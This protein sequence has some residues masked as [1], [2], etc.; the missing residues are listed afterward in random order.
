MGEPIADVMMRLFSWMSVAM[1]KLTFSSITLEDLKSVIHLQEGTIGRYDWN[2]VTSIALTDQEQR[3]VTEVSA[4]LLDRDT[5]LMNEAT[6]WGKAIFP[7]LTLAESEN[8]EAWAEVMLRAQYELFALEGLA[9][10]VLGRSV[11][12]RV[13]APYLVVVEAKKGIEAQSPVYQLYGQLLAAAHLNWELDGEAVQEIFGCYTIGDVW[14]FVRAEVSGIKSD[15]PTL[16]T[17][18]SREYVEKLEAETILKLLKG[19]VLRHLDR[20]SKASE[21]G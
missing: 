16:K 20:A 10:G 6:V 18:Y 19:I 2:E 7:L 8:V 13:E 14:K 17:E 3:R 15:R 12:G 4:Y 21:L 1:P 11:I 9:D 5:T